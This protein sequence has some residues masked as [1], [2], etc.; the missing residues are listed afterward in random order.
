MGLDVQ[1]DFLTVSK[2]HHVAEGPLFV[3][4]LSEYSVHAET[5]TYIN[6]PDFHLSFL[7]H[8]LSTIKSFLCTV[9]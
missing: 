1:K 2:H 3:L 5:L 7:A 9:L 4:L 6:I 8:S